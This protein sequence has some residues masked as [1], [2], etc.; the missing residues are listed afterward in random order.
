M[1][2]CVLVNKNKI[3]KRESLSY[4]Y[5]V[6]STWNTIL[7]ISAIESKKKNDSSRDTAV[8]PSGRLS[9]IFCAL[10]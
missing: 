10:F 9:S 2:I 5:P 7:S 4:C 3:K 8:N 1:W 6:A